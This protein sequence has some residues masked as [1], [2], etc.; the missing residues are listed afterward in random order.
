MLAR[1]PGMYQEHPKSSNYI[2]R[3]FGSLKPIEMI[4]KAEADNSTMEKWRTAHED[5]SEVV[6]WDFSDTPIDMVRNRCIEEAQLEDCDYVL[7]IDADMAPDQPRPLCKPFWETAWGFLRRRQAPSVIAAP[8]VGPG[9]HQNIYVFRWRGYNEWNRP[10]NFSLQ[11]YTREEAAERTGIEQVA[12]LPTGLIIYDT[13]VFERAAPPYFYYEMNKARSQKESTEDVT[14]TRDL[15]LLWHDVP[16]AG[17][18]CAWDC[19]ARHIKLT[20]F[21]GPTLLTT[22][23]VGQSLKNAWEKGFEPGDRVQIVGDSGPPASG[24]LADGRLVKKDA[25]EFLKKV[26]EQFP[27]FVSPKLLDPPGERR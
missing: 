12:A 4:Y 26:R 16:E 8:Y 3:V 5:F 11:Q 9:W 13:R 18:Y 27:E 1:F 10:V 25:Q 17:I 24:G 22:A 6:L 21:G 15:A 14:N 2:R 19:W 20:E 7:M 23:A